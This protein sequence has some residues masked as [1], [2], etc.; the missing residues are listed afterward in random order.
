MQNMDVVEAVDKCLRDIT[1]VDRLSGGYP[2]VLGVNWAQILPVVPRGSRGD[3]V[4]A[5][6]QQ[7]YVWSSLQQVF[8]QQNMQ[9][10]D[11]GSEPYIKWLRQ[12]SSSPAFFGTVELPQFFSVVHDL[13]ELFFSAFFLLIDF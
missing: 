3:I 5:C 1:K 13:R 9:A 6:Q 4:N 2:V 7:S 10:V 12:M 8:L 11:P